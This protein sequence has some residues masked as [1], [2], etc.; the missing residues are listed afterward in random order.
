METKELS[1]EDINKISE[2]IGKKVFKKFAN[3]LSDYVAIHSK[4]YD[5]ILAID[6]IEIVLR[7]M[8]LVDINVIVRL[9]ADHKDLT[10][11]NL[12]AGKIFSAYVGHMHENIEV[13][14]RNMMKER[15]N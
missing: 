6:L 10:G 13:M 3:E 5:T 12:D 1:I 2:L 8:S 9:C 14:K 4:K 11:T 7:A 15:M